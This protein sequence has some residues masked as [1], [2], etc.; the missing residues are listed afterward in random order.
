V[1]QTQAG[2]T[3]AA[4]AVRQA[5]RP[6]RSSETGKHDVSRIHKRCR[7]FRVAVDGDRETRGKRDGRERVGSSSWR[8]CCDVMLVRWCWHADIFLTAPA[9]ATAAA[10]AAAV[11]LFTPCCCHRG[12]WP[13]MFICS[14]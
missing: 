11:A 5:D 1:R 7:L 12:F 4:H 13:G 8:H 10:A 9:A 6:A 14:L 2:D 3:G